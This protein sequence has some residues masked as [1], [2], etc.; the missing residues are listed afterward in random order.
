MALAAG[1]AV[2]ALAI[3]AAEALQ[4]WPGAPP[5]PVADLLETLA[6]A[7]VTL[8]ALHRRWREG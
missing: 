5:G 8:D 4:L 3:R 7:G 2:A 6:L 1:I